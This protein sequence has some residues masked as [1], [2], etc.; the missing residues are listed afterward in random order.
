MQNDTNT[1]GYSQWFFFSIKNKNNR[2][3][4]LNIV[5]FVKK[6]LLFTRGIKPLGFSIK[7]Y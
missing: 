7:L 1:K 4:K 3:I 2:K 6:N 5:N